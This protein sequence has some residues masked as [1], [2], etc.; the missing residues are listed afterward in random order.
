MRE[1]PDHWA[2]ARGLTT[3]FIRR[4][5]ELLIKKPSASDPKASKAWPSMRTWEMATRLEAGSAIHDLGPA[6]SEEL[7]SAYIGNGPAS[8]FFKWKKELDL[9]DPAAILDGAITFKHDPKRLDLSIAILSA[10]SALVCPQNAKDRKPRAEKLW[11][12]LDGVAKDAAD[13]VVPPAKQMIKSRLVMRGAA[14][15]VLTRINPVLKAA[16]IHY[17]AK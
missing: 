5:P 7:V 12:I 10:C 11:E 8:E 1:W 9:P 17:A 16:G 2:K 13:L 14:D 6:D 15:A 4:R 3:G